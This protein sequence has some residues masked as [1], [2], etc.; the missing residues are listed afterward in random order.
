MFIVDATG[1][2]LHMPLKVSSS[3]T[4]CDFTLK[5]YHT[6]RGVGVLSIDLHMPFK[7]SS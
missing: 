1:T 4:L 2:G 6:H 5:N 3:K 7:V